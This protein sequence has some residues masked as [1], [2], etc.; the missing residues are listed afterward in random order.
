[1]T[2]ADAVP[3]LEVDG[4][5]VWF[6]QGSRTLPIVHD[7]S[8]QMARGE[9]VAIVGPSGSGK[10]VTAR[11][12]LGL[13]DGLGGR[14]EQRA[15]ALSL[16]GT[17]LRTLDERGWRQ[18]RGSR[19][20]LVLQDALV[21]LDPLKRVGHEVGEVLR[22]HGIGGSSQRWARVIESL[23]AV[24]LPDPE[25]RAR[26]FP[27]ELSGGM[28]Q[29]ALIASAVAGQPELLIADEPTTALDV[30]VQ[31][32]VIEVLRELRDAGASILLISH[33]L[34]V[35]AQLADRVLVMDGGRI[36]EQG[37]IGEVLADPQHATTKA[38]LRA[39]EHAARHKGTAGGAPAGGAGAGKKSVLEGHGLRKV[40]ALPG[41][42]QLVA[43]ADASVALWPGRITGVVGE[44]GSG[45]STLASMMLALTA[46][47]AGSV[48]YRGGPFSALPERRR[49]ALRA[50]IQVIPQDPF[51]SFD[52]RARVGAIVEEPLLLHT[53]LDRRTRRQRVID[54]LGEVGLGPE[55]LDRRPH[56]LSGGQRQR[57]AIAR[58]LITE[59]AV[60]VCDEPLSA[61]DVMIQQQVLALLDDLVRRRELATLFISHDLGI[62]HQICDYV[63]V[64]K[65]G[66]VVEQGD[67]N[68]VY[69]S[70][71]DPYS[72][73][74]LA[75]VPTIRTT[76]PR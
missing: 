65:D 29:R 63:L 19:I 61:L 21:S 66:E 2:A 4:L 6:R 5:D 18:V 22:T 1:M 30:T 45:K 68:Q 76:P 36:V 74:L 48:S 52:P 35:V 46:P 53:Q 47:T 38:L 26:Q 59:P 10:S 34:A 69:D 31:A 44:S 56:Q 43:V 60:L 11:A 64:M 16:G 33:D 9:T 28:R 50:E 41:G 7:V 49:R 20:G 72:Q 25:V 15:R 73:R 32:Q 3:L 17:D 57:V 54:Q 67:I 14:S 71:Q 23:R 8:F 51:G 75:A 42:E 37:A 58:A 55:L 39:A 27:H 13:A 62:V 70:P 24:G 12:L 40:Y